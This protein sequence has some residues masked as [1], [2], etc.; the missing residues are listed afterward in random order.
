MLTDVWQGCFGEVL[1]EMMIAYFMYFLS[2]TNDQRGRSCG[3]TRTV[4]TAVTWDQRNLR[5]KVLFSWKPMSPDGGTTTRDAEG[6][7]EEWSNSN[8]DCTLYQHLTTLSGR[9]PA[10]SS[11]GLP[12]PAGYA[13]TIARPCTHN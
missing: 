3:S 13:W 10:Y 1:G 5:I 4:L 12:M 11:F 9:E 2:I 6:Y 7:M 8:V